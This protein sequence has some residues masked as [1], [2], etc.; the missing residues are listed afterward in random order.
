MICL[1]G[2]YVEVFCSPQHGEQAYIVSTD[3]CWWFW[4]EGHS[5][6]HVKRMKIFSED[7]NEKPSVVK[8]KG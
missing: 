1:F 7:A 8:L 5:Q 3:K 6:K 4:T 2:P